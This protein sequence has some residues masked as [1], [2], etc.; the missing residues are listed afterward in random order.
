[1]DADSAPRCLIGSI[2]HLSTQGW[3]LI[4]PP[5]LLPLPAWSAPWPVEALVLILLGEVRT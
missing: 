3:V 5:H 1:M 2:Q 4:C